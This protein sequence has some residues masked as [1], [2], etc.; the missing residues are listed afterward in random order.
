MQALR[1][2]RL[3]ELLP[4]PLGA[5]A[6]W[7]LSTARAST[8][9]CARPAGTEASSCS[10]RRCRRSVERRP[11]TPKRKSSTGEM[12]AQ[13]D[14]ALP[15]KRRVANPRP[16]TSR[17][18]PPRR[19]TVGHADSDSKSGSFGSIFTR[20]EGAKKPNVHGRF[21]PNGETRIRTGD[22][23]IFSRAPLGS[24]LKPQIIQKNRIWV[25]VL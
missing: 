2:V 24:T 18:E 25:M 16:R 22:T 8:G 4:H 15:W 10:P 12:L 6:G 17:R 20:C 21:V 19:R 14:G 9:S 23:T 1:T 7:H 11:S 5:H 3:T 13:S